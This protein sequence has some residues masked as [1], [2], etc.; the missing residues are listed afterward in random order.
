MD[1]WIALHEGVVGP[2]LRDFTKLAGCNE[3]E[4]LGILDY[5]WLW[6]VKDNADSS[7]LLKKAN[8]NDIADVFALKIDKSRDPMKVAQALVDAGWIDEMDGRYYIHDWPEI[9]RASCRERVS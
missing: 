2:K 7:G 5:V 6:A 4:A 9:G 1:R 3:A 8:L